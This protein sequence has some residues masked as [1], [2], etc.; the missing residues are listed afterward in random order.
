MAGICYWDL[1]DYGK[2]EKELN[3]L[4]KLMKL[5]SRSGG[6]YVLSYEFLMAG[7]YYH[8]G[9]SYNCLHLLLRCMS[10]GQPIS[11]DQ[12]IEALKWISNISY[13]QG[14]RKAV[15]RLALEAVGKCSGDEVEEIKKALEENIENKNNVW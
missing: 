15:Y 5:L 14:Y 9:M 6:K 2:A 7:V 4:L 12:Q 10:Y 1:K 3:D 8:T 11:A 13:T